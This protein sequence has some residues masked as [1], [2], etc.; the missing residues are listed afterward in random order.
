MEPFAEAQT[1]S[2]RL[3]PRDII[4]VSPTTITKVNQWVEQF[5]NR[6]IPN[7]FAGPVYMYGAI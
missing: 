7:P 4:Y 1:A 6:M 5:I 2:V 3:A